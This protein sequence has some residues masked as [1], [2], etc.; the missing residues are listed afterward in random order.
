MENLGDN[1]IQPIIFNEI[2]GKPDTFPPS[3]HRHPYWKFTG[4]S[5]LITPLDRILNGVYFQD[6]EKYRNA[7]DYWYSKQGQFETAFTFKVRQL[8]QQKSKVD[9]NKLS[10]CLELQAD[11]YAGL[12]AH[13]NKKYLEEGDIE[14]ALSV[15]GNVLS[16]IKV[17]PNPAKNS[18]N[19]N[20]NNSITGEIDYTLYDIQGRLMMNK[21]SSSAITNLNIENLTE[22]IYLLV[23]ETENVK[24]TKKVVVKR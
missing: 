16:D 14:E 12:W 11:F 10:V 23:I 1:L 18:I 5:E 15:E 20:L 9:G 6:H 4:W 3:A 13:F 21:K 22:G 17:Y 8:Q 2:I 24:S 19:I 7:Y